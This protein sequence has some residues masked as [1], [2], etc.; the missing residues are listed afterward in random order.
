[1]VD[2]SVGVVPVTHVD[3]LKDILTDE[4]LDGSELR[5]RRKSTSAE[6]KPKP[7]QSESNPTSLYP[8]D[9]SGPHGSRMIEERLYNGDHPIYDAKAMAGLPIGVQIVGRC[10]EDEKVVEMMKIVDN[11]LKTARREPSFGPG[12]SRRYFKDN[13]TPTPLLTPSPSSESPS[14]RK[15]LRALQRL[16]V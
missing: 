1:M 13:E 9:K 16:C 4:W 5:S 15:V 7:P 8:Y 11:A 3:P 12:S 6:T 14:P 2:S 10:F